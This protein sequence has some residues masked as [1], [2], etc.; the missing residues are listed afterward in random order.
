MKRRFIAA[1]A[2]AAFVVLVMCGSVVNGQA[3]YP[4]NTPKFPQART[5]L[6]QKAKLPPYKAPRTTDGVPNLQGNWGGPVGGGNDDLE[7]HDYI[8]V[9]TPPQ[10]SYVSD[11]ADGKVPYMPWALAKRNEIRAGLGRGWPGETGRRLYGDPAALCLVGA[12]LV[13]RRAGN[14]PEARLRDHAHGGHVSVIPTDGRPHM[15]PGANSSSGTP[16]AGGGQTLV[17][18][19]TGI[20]GETWVDSAGNFYGPNTHMIERWTMVEP[21]TIDYAITIEDPTIYTRP[22]TMN[23]AKRRAGDARRR[24]CRR[25]RRSGEDR[26]RR[27]GRGCEKRSLR[28]RSV[29]GDVPRGE[30]GQH[31]DPEKARVQ[32]VR[33]RDAAEVMVARLL[34]NGGRMRRTVRRSVWGV[35]PLVAAA[36]LGDATD[37]RS[38]RREERRVDDLRRRPRQHAV[39]AA[40]SDQRRQLQQARGRLAVQDRQPRSAARVPVR[41]DAADGARRPLLDRRHAAGGRRARRGHRRAAVDAQRARRRRAA[42]RRPASSPAAASRTGPTAARNGSSTSRPAIGSSRSTQRPA[43]RSRASARTASS[44]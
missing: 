36:H 1:I 20:N 5:W 22:W 28:E 17:V 41:V 8:D 25:G 14:H 16:V 23:Y 4:P 29:G 40:R 26:G 18:D 42:R 7:E 21:N 10:E 19:V 30:C 32:V 37:C 33:P 27:G 24:W 2:A 13:V 38:I 39:F 35:V 15:D 9:T 11:P 6:V 3:F 43:I 12:A 31:R 34:V 44:I